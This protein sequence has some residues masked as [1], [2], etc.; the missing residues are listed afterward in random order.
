MQKVHRERDGASG[1]VVR[2]RG[3]GGGGSRGLGGRSAARGE[4]ALGW[5][6]AP[7]LGRG[8]GLCLEFR[9]SGTLLRGLPPCGRTPLLAVLRVLELWAGSGREGGGVWG[10]ADE[11]GAP[12]LGAGARVWILRGRR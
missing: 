3:A 4:G 8:R 6:L 1:G 9:R 11:G 5:V 12:R 7:A 10:L 2:P